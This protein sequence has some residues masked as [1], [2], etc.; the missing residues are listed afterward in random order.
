[1]TEKIL[2]ELGIDINNAEVTLEQLQKQLKEANKEF[3]KAAVGS[4][5]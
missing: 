3:S 5:A 4:K 2:L 1:M